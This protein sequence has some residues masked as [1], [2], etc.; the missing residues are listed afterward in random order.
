MGY[1]M[2]NKVLGIREGKL[3]YVTIFIAGLLAGI[4][5]M[6]LGKSVWLENTGLMDEDTLYHMK[7]MTVD[8]AALFYYV[9]RQRLLGILLLALMAS[10]YLGLVVCGGVAFWYGICGGIFLATALIRYGMKGILLVIVGIFP[11]YLIYVP[12]MIGMLLWCQ[13]LYRTI[14]LDKAFARNGRDAS[15]L[16]GRLMQFAGL[17]ALFVIGCVLESFMN[18]VL[19]RGLLKIF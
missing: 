2:H 13:K 17:L 1:H 3:P 8:R 19:L 14:Y 12:A 6:N 10:T 4:I 5:I 7:Y 16:T 9:L 15:I 11:Q 18:P